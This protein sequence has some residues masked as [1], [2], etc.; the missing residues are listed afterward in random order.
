MTEKI[1]IVGNGFLGCNIFSSSVAH[2]IKPIVA[3]RSEHNFLDVTQ[4]HSIEKIVFEYKPDFIINCAA[5]TKI[6]DIEIEPK[7][8]FKINAYGAQNIA[9]V[10]NK[11]KIKMMHIS[12]DS[13]FDGKK[14]MYDENS[15]TNPLNEYAK[16]KKLG[17][18]LV[19]ETSDEFIVVRTNF[20]GYNNEGRFL[21][22]WILQNFRDNREFVGFDDVF[23]N[24][25]EITNLSEMLI[26][27][28]KLDF[29]GIIH[30]AANK[31]ISKYEFG[32]KISEVLGFNSDLIKKGSLMKSKFVAKRPLNTSLSNK[33]AKRILKTKF[34]N[35]EEWLKMNN[36]LRN[37]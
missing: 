24:P 2:N 29:S 12:T 20:Y 37:R 28:L 18:D 26:E 16:S 11:N 3:S 1:L 30:L 25:L 32:L 36:N 27:L 34:L 17:E 31:A 6:D 19:M 10:A 13:V 15:I 5:L 22:N 23:F 7:K 21:F 8:A 14:G 9:Q 33:K 35:I 4:K